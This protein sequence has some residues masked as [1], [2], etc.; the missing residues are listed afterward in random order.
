MTALDHYN[1]PELAQLYDDENGWDES[2]DFYLDLARRLGARTLLDL[3]CGTGTVTRGIV[4][5][6]GCRA[7]GIDP[8]EPML[9]VARRNTKRETVEWFQGDAREIRLDDRFDLI[10]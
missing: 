4:Q 10:I 5:A 2:A 1:Q 3:G 6:T 8:A 9:E 7:V